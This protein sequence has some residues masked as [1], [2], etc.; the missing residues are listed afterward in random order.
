[1][2]LCVGNEHFYRHLERKALFI[3]WATLCMRW[4]FQNSNLKKELLDYLEGLFGVDMF[5]KKAVTSAAG[6]YLKYT[7]DVYRR[8]LAI[9]PWYGR[10]PSILEREWKAI[11]DDAK[12]KILK[13]S[14]EQITDTTR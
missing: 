14:G 3:F 7:R 11:I 12:K 5:N 2:F 6:E 8:I 13:K 4:N 10:P 1:M 9:N